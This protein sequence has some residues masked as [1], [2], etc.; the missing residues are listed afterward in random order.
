MKPYS[1]PTRSNMQPKQLQGKTIIF[2]E[3]EDNI[4][5]FK[6]EEDLIF[7]N[8]RRPQKNN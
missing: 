7:S 6:T 2:L 3:M 4:N 8:G 5:Y 1:N